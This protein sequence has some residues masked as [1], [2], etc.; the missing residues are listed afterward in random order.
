MERD[1][2]CGMNVDPDRAAA[3]VEHGGKT[4]Y[5]CAP[6]CAKRFQQAPGKYLQPAKDLAAPS[7]LVTLQST[8]QSSAAAAARATKEAKQEQPE[9]SVAPAAGAAQHQRTAD[10]PPAGDTQV[11][12]TCPMHPEIVQ[13]G[14]G[15]CPICGMAL[16]PIDVLAE[17][18]ADPEYDSMRLRFWASA[19]LSVPLLVLAMFGES[20]GVHLAPST[21]HWIELALATPVVL[22][23]GWPF[24][25]RFW[26]SLVNRSPNMFTL[27]GLGTGAAY[28]DSVV[29]TVFP[30]IF[31][32]SFRDMHGAVP[33]YFEAAAI[34]TTLVLLGQV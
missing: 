22:W 25:Q 3:K 9:T 11:R 14:P 21:L 8:S 13:N 2:V 27:I 23:G 34:I 30:Q 4:Y 24:F 19:V 20:L 12:Y 32:A 18:E 5:F 29:A 16:E 10:K 26:A 28:L 31:P 1:P 6:G 15:F 17:I 7:G 33:V